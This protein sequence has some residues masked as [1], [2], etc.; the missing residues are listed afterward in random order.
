EGQHLLDR[1]F[2]SGTTALTDVVVEDRA[3]VPAVRRAVAGV[4]G[5]ESVSGPVSE[6]PP[7]TLIQATLEISPYS[8]EPFDLVEPIPEAPPQVAPSTRVGG[9]TAVEFDVRDAAGWDSIVIPP[10]IL[11]VVFL[12]L[13]GLLRA[14][15]APLIL[16]GTV[17]LSFLAALGV[18]YFT[19]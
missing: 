6:G 4:E 12:I 19:F 15:V 16:I 11:V 8:T 7:G 18:G 5:V 13:M 9:P 10:I 14:V 1:S 2:P 3:D 17:I